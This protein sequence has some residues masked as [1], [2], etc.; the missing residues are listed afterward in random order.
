M[1]INAATSGLVND[2]LHTCED[3][4]TLVR[5]KG[6]LVFY[7]QSVTTD[8]V[9]HTTIRILPGGISI[10]G[11]EPSETEDLDNDASDTLLLECLTM[12]GKEDEVVDVWEFDSKA[13]RK[14]KVGDQINLTTKANEASWGKVAGT[15]TLWFKE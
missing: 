4:K 1:V 8:N 2:V 12:G 3:S 7:Q 6:R 11:D 13:M 15:V 14:L 10:S 9:V 5:I